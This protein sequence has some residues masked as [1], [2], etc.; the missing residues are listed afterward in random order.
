MHP[1]LV[2]C[3]RQEQAAEILRLQQEVDRLASLEEARRNRDLARRLLREFGLPDP[4]ATDPWAKTISGEQFLESLLAAKN[5]QAMRE[6]VEERA[7]LVR[8]L[9]GAEKR[10]Q[11]RDQ[12]QV[13]APVPLNTKSFVEAIT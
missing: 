8:T 3:I 2:E 9:V 7:R 11:S 4:E 10:P 1:E 5:E 13:Y 6:L 12:H